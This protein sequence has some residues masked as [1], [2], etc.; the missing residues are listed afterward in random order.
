LDDT[1][2][3]QPVQ[4]KFNLRIGCWKKNV[5]AVMTTVDA[6][7]IGLPIF[8]LKIE[9]VGKD[10]IQTENIE[11]S[12]L[13]RQNRQFFNDFAGGFASDRCSFES[14]QLI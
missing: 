4:R 13:C 9:H 1:L 6:N 8:S 2:T 5:A 3:S 11:Q 12:R 10:A 14:D 7:M